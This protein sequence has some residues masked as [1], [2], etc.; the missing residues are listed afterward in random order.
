[1]YV[2]E[3]TPGSGLLRNDF[4]NHCNSLHG[5]RR[6]PKL[7]KNNLLPSASN[8]CVH[9]E[10][11]KA[12][13]VPIKKQNKKNSAGCAHK[14]F[15]TQPNRAQ[16]NRTTINLSRILITRL[17]RSDPGASVLTLPFQRLSLTPRDR[18]ERFSSVHRR[19]GTN[20]TGI[21]TPRLRRKRRRKCE[22]VLQT[23]RARLPSRT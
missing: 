21:S 16:L 20:A 1:M 17:H 4:R 18:P 9:T 19:H 7:Y 15:P 13:F 12:S 10:T 22:D 6:M 8:S 3:S 5:V 23:K 14:L 11:Q 2:P